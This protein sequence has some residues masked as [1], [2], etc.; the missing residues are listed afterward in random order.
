LV[1]SR[2]SQNCFCI[3]KVK[4]RV[5]GSQDHD[6]L[7]VHDGLTTM[8][9]HS[10]S[11]AQEVVVIA[12]RE[13]RSSRFSPMTQLGGGVMEMATRRHSTK[14]TSG[15]PMGDG[16]GREERLELGWLRWIIGVL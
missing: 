2:I 11:R 5:Y 3:G 6:W 15:A 8:G 7:S 12:H 1:F 16:S 4:D 13:R 14:A 9:W 10:R